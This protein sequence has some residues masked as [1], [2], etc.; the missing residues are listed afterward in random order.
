MS[1]AYWAKQQLQYNYL[2]ENSS[3]F[4][5]DPSS[6]SFFMPSQ[7]PATE[8]EI[9]TVFS[10]LSLLH[11]NFALIFWAIRESLFNSS[12]GLPLYFSNTYNSN[13]F[14]HAT[15]FRYLKNFFSATTPKYAYAYY[16]RLD[17]ELSG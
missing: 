11:F 4:L 17:D 15:K 16:Q 10:P 7:L 13:Q 3:N 2:N 1:F 9:K 14:S 8:I 5:I 12:S 6:S